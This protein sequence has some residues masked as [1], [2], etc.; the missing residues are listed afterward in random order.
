MPDLLGEGWGFEVH[1]VGELNQAM[2]DAMR[3]RSYSI[4]NVHLDRNDVS[5]ALNRLAERLAKRL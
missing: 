4:L 5:R 2:R 3:T 1:T